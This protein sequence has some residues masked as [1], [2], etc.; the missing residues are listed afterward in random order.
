MIIDKNDQITIEGQLVIYCQ[1]LVVSGNH[2]TEQNV[3]NISMSI[4]N[5]VGFMVGRSKYH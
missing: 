3:Y 2:F 1:K 5:S 4:S